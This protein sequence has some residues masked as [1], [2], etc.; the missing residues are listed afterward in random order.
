MVPVTSVNRPR[1]LVTMKWRPTKARS[2]WPGSI[3]QRP[4]AGRTCPSMLRVAAGMSVVMSDKM[5][6]PSLGWGRG[7]GGLG[8]LGRV[9]GSDPVLDALGVL[10]HIRVAGTLESV[11][12]CLAIA[13]RLVGAVGDDRG[14]LVGQEAGR[15]RLD[16]ALDEV[17]RAGQVDLV[18]VGGRQGVD[19]DDV[20]L[21]KEC[22]QLGAGD[23]GGHNRILSVK[24]VRTH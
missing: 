16:V 15:K 1:T 6:F 5:M 2:V 19:V 17:E 8:R 18:V 4:A 11:R 14:V 3:S 21:G 10:A 24:C 22:L 9:A 20:S 12:H 23:G 13:A 7:S